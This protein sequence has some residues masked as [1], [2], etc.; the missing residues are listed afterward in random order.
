MLRRHLVDFIESAADGSVVLRCNTAE[1][2][3]VKSRRLGDL[4]WMGERK[5]LRDNL[6]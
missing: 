4:V 6:L 2:T 5:A 3:S 1:G